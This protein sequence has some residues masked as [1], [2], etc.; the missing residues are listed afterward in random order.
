M[1]NELITQ[2]KTSNSRQ[3]NSSN[4]AEGINGLGCIMQKDDQLAHF[5]PNPF[6]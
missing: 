1:K 2:P 4:L 6:C 5:I 3:K